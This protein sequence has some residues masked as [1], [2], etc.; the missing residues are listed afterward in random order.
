MPIS[1]AMRR[2]VPSWLLFTIVTCGA[3]LVL[4]GGVCWAEFNRYRSDQ[5]DGLSAV[6]EQAFASRQDTF[7]RCIA[8]A[9]DIPATQRCEAEASATAAQDFTSQSDL[10]SQLD[11]S[12]WSY[13]LLLLTIVSTTVSVFGLAALLVSL[14]QTW[15][16]IRNSR[17]IGEAQI[18]AY[19]HCSSARYELGESWIQVT[20]ELANTGQSP[21]S[22]IQVSGKATI[23]AV[24]GSPDHT[25][26]LFWRQSDKS[27]AY[28]E[29]VVTG[30]TKSI[31]LTFFAS[32]F[33]HADNADPLELDWDTFNRVWCELLVG[34]QDVFGNVQQFPL[35]LEADW[36]SFVG[37]RTRK[38]RTKGDLAIRVGD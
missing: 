5:L 36:L 30:A 4:A 1:S 17:E 12:A 37:P 6:A 35:S 2:S 20:V 29:P 31:S 24:G 38:K 7:S 3:S 33:R 28:G 15:T 11:M 34:W 25:R 9:A 18:R 23:S 19:L 21:A 32:D 27:E 8:A 13:A 22:D 26:V 14:R 16:A 10:R